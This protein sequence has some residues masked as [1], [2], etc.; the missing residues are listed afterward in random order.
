[1]IGVKQLLFF[2]IFN[3]AG[4]K[5]FETRDS[6]Q[7]WDGTVNGAMQPMDSYMW[8]V[9]ALDKYGSPIRL[10]GMTTLIR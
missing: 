4:V 2:R 7:G 9:E 10:R 1:M 8:V 3:K 5:V 6:S